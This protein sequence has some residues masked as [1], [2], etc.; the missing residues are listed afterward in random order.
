MAINCKWSSVLGKGIKKYPNG[1]ENVITFYGG[2]NV[3]TC[4]CYENKNLYSFI[5]DKEHAKAWLTKQELDLENI[6]I[7]IHKDKHIDKESRNLAKIFI[8][9]KIPFTYKEFE[10]SI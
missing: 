10:Y 5:I 6:E 7:Y 8:E 2:G 3:V 4:M 1:K 9:Q